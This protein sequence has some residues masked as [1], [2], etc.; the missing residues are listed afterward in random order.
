MSSRAIYVAAY[1][2]ILATI[3]K[4]KAF[5]V[6]TNTQRHVR[7]VY[8]C[9]DCWCWFCCCLGTSIH[10]YL[11]L[12]V[13]QQ[14]VVLLSI[15][16]VIYVQV[17]VRNA[18][19]SL[20]QGRKKDT[21][22]EGER[23]KDRGNDMGIAKARRIITDS[24]N[25]FYCPAHWPM[26]VRTS[27]SVSSTPVLLSVQLESVCYRFSVVSQVVA[28]PVCLFVC[29]SVCVSACLSVSAT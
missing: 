27:M 24:Q 22:R 26:N 18:V 29:A 8:F 13:P 10:A 25:N 12:I 28:L 21:D 17:F 16:A 3:C 7:D 4:C 23:K 14:R 19:L 5:Y 1:L 20:P 15:R 6:G 9:C 2:R 11:L